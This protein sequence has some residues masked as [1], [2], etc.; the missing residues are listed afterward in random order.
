MVGDTLGRLLGRRLWHSDSRSDRTVAVHPLCGVTDPGAIADALLG[1]SAPREHP[2][3]EVVVAEISSES[4]EV[5]LDTAET[6]RRRRRDVSP[7]L[8]GIPVDEDAVPTVAHAFDKTVLVADRNRERIRE[9]LSFLPALYRGA[10]LDLSGV[11]SARSFSIDVSECAPD[12]GVLAPDIRARKGRPFHDSATPPDVFA[13]A[14][15]TEYC[16]VTYS[17]LS[18]IAPVSYRFD[19]PG[20]SI[21]VVGFGVEHARPPSGAERRDSSTSRVQYGH[22][23]SGG[24]Q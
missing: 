14:A 3:G 9:L 19:R 1:D 6:L 8:I 16:D 5:L 15:P 17:A 4:E 24:D 21:T 2:A 22:P 20:D 10:G 12:D 23:P 11:G 13:F 7:C 18:E